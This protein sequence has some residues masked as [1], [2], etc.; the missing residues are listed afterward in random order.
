MANPMERGRDERSDRGG[1]RGLRLFVAIEVP[2]VVRR[3][4]KRRL[5]GLRDRLPRA[6]WVDPDVLH[7]TLVFLGEVA[8]DRLAA[9]AAALAK[10]MAPLPP[11]PLRLAG[12]GTFPEG[13]AAR[14]A[15]LGVEAPDELFRLQQAAAD[16]AVVTVGHQPEERPYRAHVTLAR[17][18]SPWPRAAGDKFRA[19][20]AGTIGQPFTAERAVLLESTL[21]PHGPRYR[22]RAALPLRG[23]EVTVAELAGGAGGAS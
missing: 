9:L 23:A 19:A 20:F 5:A 15:W 21:S 7:L 16:A 8:G 17:C 6:R 14:V 11:L 2:E 12:G 22:E 3:D 1:E 18:P 4:V 13:R 10:A